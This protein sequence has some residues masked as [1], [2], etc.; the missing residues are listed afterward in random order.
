MAD[1]WSAPKTCCIFSD[2]KAQNPAS[3]PSGLMT[4][5]RTW[6]VISVMSSVKC[7]PGGILHGI[8]ADVKHVQPL[9]EEESVL[10]RR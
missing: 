5:N 1:G 4:V 6:T 8:I 3:V 7:N 10:Q 9:L 2:S